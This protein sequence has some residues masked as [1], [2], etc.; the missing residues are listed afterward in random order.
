MNDRIAMIETKDTMWT[1]EIHER[2]SQKDKTF[3][4]NCSCRRKRFDSAKE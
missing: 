3:F 1:K 2:R 4:Y